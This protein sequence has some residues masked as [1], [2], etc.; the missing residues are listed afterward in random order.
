MKPLY[1]TLFCLLFNFYCFANPEG[2]IIQLNWDTHYQVNAQETAYAYAHV[3]TSDGGQI[4]VGKTN[5]KGA[6]K[7]DGWIYKTDQR[8]TVVWERTIGGIEDDVLQDIVPTD[9]GGFL[10]SGS[11]NSKGNGSFDVWLLKVNIQGVLQWHRTHGTKNSEQGGR[12]VQNSNG[13]YLMAATRQYGNQVM[14]QTEETYVVKHFIWLLKFDKQGNLLLDER[15]PVNEHLAITDLHQTQEGGY[16]L[17]AISNTKGTANAENAL[18]L[19]TDAQGMVAW[20]RWIGNAA[21]S[22]MIHSILPMNNNTYILAGHASNKHN[23]ADVNGWVLMLDGMGN[24]IWQKL[25]GTIGHGLEAFHKIER[26]RDH[27]LLLSGQS[28][29]DGIMGN[30]EWIVKTNYNGDILWQNDLSQPI[31]SELNK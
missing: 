17:S 25:Y 26:T 23:P 4:W 28:Y 8:G 31:T 1:F 30:Q 27:H 11:T 9:D 10:L 21:V 2:Q 5:S 29:Q 18:I 19:K 15:V 6:G 13:E 12:I 24:I 7:T 14:T 16:I 3:P 20:K 22:D